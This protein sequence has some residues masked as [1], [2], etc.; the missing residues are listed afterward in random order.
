[1]LISKIFLG[2]VL[3]LL[4][5]LPLHAQSEEDDAGRPRDE[6]L[7]MLHALPVYGHPYGTPVLMKHFSRR[8]SNIIPTD[9]TTS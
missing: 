3:L 9:T 4:S 6:V 1:M 8:W 7:H 2:I 5:H